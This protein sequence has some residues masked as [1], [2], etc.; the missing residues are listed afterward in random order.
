MR[1]SPVVVLRSAASALACALAA[2]LHAQDAAPEDGAP[3]P[4][5]TAAGQPEQFTAPVAIAG[6]TIIPITLEDA[7]QL[8][9]ASNLGLRSESFNRDVAREALVIANAEFEPL[10][11]LSASQA[12]SENPITANTTTS[13]S[14]SV[15]RGNASVSQRIVTGA[16]I[17]LATTMQRI[18]QAGG[19]ARVPLVFDTSASLSVRQPLL[20]GAGFRV[21][22]A[23]RDRAR[24]GVERSELSFMGQ[25]L[26]IVRDTELAFFDL[27]SAHYALDV[28][29]SGLATAQQ[30]LDE[31][32]ARRS[33]GIATELDVMQAR[34]SVANRRSVIITAE[35]R[36]RDATDRLLALFGRRDF[37]GILQPT[38]YVF[39]PPASLSV[40]SAYGRAAEN[41]TQ[42]RN[43][44][45]LLR[46]LE[47][48]AMVARSNRRPRLDI[49][50]V[51][52]L[53]GTDFRTLEGALDRIPDGDEF[54][55][56]AGVSLS[57]PWGMNEARARARTAETYIAQQQ[58][59]LEQLEQELMVSIRAA[60]R[61]VEADRQTI[62]IN[63]LSTE[64][65]QREFEL[66][67]AKFDSGLSTS[68]LVVEAQQRWDEAR[69]REIQ[70]R[71]QLRQDL[72]RLRRLEGGS[73]EFY[74][75]DSLGE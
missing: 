41:D 43:E 72:A 22:R 34:V 13:N 71:V 52:T 48:D 18:G 62:D 64:L 28:E 11:Q 65:S 15:T 33:A 21:N 73:L 55:W 16:E 35:Q 5:A 2:A 32:E 29:R 9:L 60:I 37:S 39:A 38:G 69:V 40:E 42:L 31:N 56:Q 20:A 74:G 27:A 61:A 75:V 53:S 50:G 58:L 67:K 59:R 26:D 36:V 49:E 7:V 8:A 66:E 63:A 23:A 30:F 12:E 14:T 24:I 25:A 46:Q 54:N 4:Q 6:E 51:Y 19:D 3:A 70:S 68:R 10:F 1:P 17:S 47:L 57:L 44:R 45:G